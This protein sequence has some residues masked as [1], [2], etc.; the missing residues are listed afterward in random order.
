MKKNNN[1]N[2]NNSNNGMTNCSFQEREI[3][4]VT[5]R[6]LPYPTRSFQ[7]AKKREKSEIAHLSKCPCH[8]INI[9]I[10]TLNEINALFTLDTDCFLQSER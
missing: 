3:I 10:Y 7:V 9:E 6:N 5:T 2:N 4:M 1:N 8:R